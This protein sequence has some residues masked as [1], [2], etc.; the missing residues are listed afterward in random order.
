M[1]LGLLLRELIRVLS[2]IFQ[3][4]H[5]YNE[6]VQGPMLDCVPYLLGCYIHSRLFK[7]IVRFLSQLLLLGALH[8][9]FLS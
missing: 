7:D 5:I 4:A 8:G 6:A 3:F 9:D 2:L 1:V